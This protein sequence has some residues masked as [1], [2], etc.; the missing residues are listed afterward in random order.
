MCVASIGV[1][2]QYGAYTSLV[3]IGGL[4]LVSL[5]ASILS[6]SPKKHSKAQCEQNSKPA[7]RARRESL[8]SAQ[9]DELRPRGRKTVS[10]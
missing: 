4:T 7:S 10:K 2:S 1:P 8:K 6:L 9:D 3:C 5:S